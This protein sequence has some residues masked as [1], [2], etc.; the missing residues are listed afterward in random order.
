MRLHVYIRLY[1]QSRALRKQISGV[2]VHFL[3]SL[4]PP[5]GLRVRVYFLRVRRQTQWRFFVVSDPKIP[6]VSVWAMTFVEDIAAL[7][8]LLGVAMHL[9]LQPAISAMHLA[10]GL[11]GRGSLPSQV[12]HR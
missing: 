7:R 2:R 8:R 10:M 3:G 9:E 4:T 11:D 6:Y 5:S 12:A 1:S